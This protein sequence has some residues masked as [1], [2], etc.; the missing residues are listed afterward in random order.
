[1]KNRLVILAFVLSI[2]AFLLSST[3]ASSRDTG[4]QG[5]CFRGS[6]LSS[7]AVALKA[8]GRCHKMVG[9]RLRAPPK[10]RLLQ[11]HTRCLEEN[12]RSGREGEGAGL[13]L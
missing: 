13:Q 6:I 8:S 5:G 12:R 9:F 1:M 2:V 11:P 3:S 7:K 10:G 4:A